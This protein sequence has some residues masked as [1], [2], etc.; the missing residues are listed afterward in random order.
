VIAAMIAEPDGWQVSFITPM[1][2]ID[3]FC[4]VRVDVDGPIVHLRHCLNLQVVS[5]NLCRKLHQEINSSK[6][7]DRARG[8]REYKMYD[9]HTKLKSCKTQ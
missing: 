7:S 5:I 6:S 9:G 4:A 3:G 2:N 1:E 8:K